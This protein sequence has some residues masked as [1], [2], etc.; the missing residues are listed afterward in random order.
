MKVLYKKPEMMQKMVAYLDTMGGKDIYKFILTKEEYDQY[1]EELKLHP[2]LGCT[3]VLFM[4]RE[5]AVEV[6]V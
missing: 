1:V 5:I 2:Q 4:D 3:N 6:M